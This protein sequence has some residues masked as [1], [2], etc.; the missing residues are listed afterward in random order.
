MWLELI[1]TCLSLC[2]SWSYCS[3]SSVR[4]WSCCKGVNSGWDF[5]T[6][7]RQFGLVRMKFGYFCL[8]YNIKVSCRW[9]GW[10]SWYS[11]CGRFSFNLKWKILNNVHK[12]CWVKSCLLLWALFMTYHQINCSSMECS[13]LNPKWYLELNGSRF[14]EI[15][16]QK[17]RWGL[18]IG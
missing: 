18:K 10:Y 7:L 5:S 1:L 3:T 11:W 4:R 14:R 16:S 15:L 9:V 17:V 6:F 13:T 12:S 2:S 8:A